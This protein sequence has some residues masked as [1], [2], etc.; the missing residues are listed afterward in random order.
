MTRFNLHEPGWHHFQNLRLTVTSEA[1]GQTF[2]GSIL[3]ND[4]GRDGALFGT[5][6]STEGQQYQGDFVIQAKNTSNPTTFLTP[7]LISDE[8]DI[9]ERLVASDRCDVYVLMSNA[10][11]TRASELTITQQLR[12]RGV[13][14]TLV[15]APAWFNKKIFENRITNKL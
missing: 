3:N 15:L 10:K 13:S 6:T 8:L 2:T 5:W 9:A 14:Q 1:F 7:S 11:L 4:A 12:T